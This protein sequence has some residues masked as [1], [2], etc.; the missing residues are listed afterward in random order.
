MK[1]LFYYIGIIGLFLLSVSCGNRWNN[2]PLRTGAENTDTYLSLLEGKRVG[3]LTNH[4]AL[5]DE[6]HLVD[7]LI[8]LGVDIRMIFAPE[9]GFRG[10]EDAGT[11]IDHH[12]D[13]ATGVPIVSVYGAGFIPADSLMQ[14]LDIAI[15]DIQDVGLRFYTYLSSMYYFMVACA[16]NDVPLIVLD[17]PNPN[18]HIVSGPVLDMQYRSFV[19]IIPIP[20]VHGMTLGE[21]ACMING[22]LWL[23]DSL[24]VS[25]T[26]VPCLNYT[27]STHY[28]LPVKPSPNLPNNRS[29]Y[30]YPSL[31]LFEG[32][33]VSLGRGTEFP[34]QVYG[35]PKMSGYD[36]S[37]RDSFGS[38]M[39]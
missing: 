28:E 18:G 33:R 15:F 22:E 8:S 3:M 6:T 29:I 24:Q 20:V 17:R 38:R 39:G 37:K 14:Q 25:L 27:H 16:R 34:F 7:S 12:T 10:N 2:E 21:L 1:C 31:C 35:H 23:P 32:T 11:R 4:T 36:F 30:L 13:G 26:V 19:G 9:H 5:I